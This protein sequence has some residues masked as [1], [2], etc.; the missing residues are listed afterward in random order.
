MLWPL[1]VLSPTNRALAKLDT[2]I[3]IAHKQVL[4]DDNTNKGEV[5]YTDLA[6]KNVVKSL[7]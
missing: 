4:V 2:I 5:V 6:A 7:R 1:L 3:L